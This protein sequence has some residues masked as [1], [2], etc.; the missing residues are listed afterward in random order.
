M[1]YMHAAALRTVDA[2]VLELQV[3]PPAGNRDIPGPQD[4]LVITP[5]EAVSS[6]RTEGCF[7][8]F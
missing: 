2:P 3:N 1:F 7:F 4:L 5:T 8:A 6:V